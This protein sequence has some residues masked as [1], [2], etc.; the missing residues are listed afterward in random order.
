MFARQG[1]QAMLC[2]NDY[3]GPHISGFS[4][5]K[6]LQKTRAEHTPVALY[7]YRLDRAA[8][9]AERVVCALA[10]ALLDRGFPVHLMSWDGADTHTFYPLKKEVIWH[11]LGFRQGLIDK[12]RRSRALAR[13]LRENGI[14]TLVGFVMSGDKAVY[15]AVKLAGV[16]LVVAERNAPCMYHVRY[17]AIQRRLSFALLHL[18]DRITVQF[19]KFSESY[20][21][22]LR[23]RIEVIPNPV[24]A[25]VRHARPGAPGQ[26]GRFTLL[27]V[28]RLDSVQKRLDC[29]LHAFGRV[30]AEQKDWDLRIIGDGPEGMALRELVCKLGI[31]ERVHFEG[32]TP[33]IFAAYIHAHLFVIPSLWE[34]FPNALA[35]ALSHGLPAVGFENAPGVADLIK[36]GDTGWLAKG[37]DDKAALGRTLRQA[38]A[39]HQERDRRGALAIESMAAYD[40]ETQ[41]DRWTALLDSLTA[42]DAS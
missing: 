27:T 16:R 18:A 35:E 7:F 40:A 14:R 28:S 17:S 2:C 19:Q 29:L 21:V 30:S 11:R 13:V 37:V 6:R 9:G 8:G 20:P 24:P 33:D 4:R 5:S 15:T 1:C 26:N 12:I 23:D 34:G 32:S 36:D 42:E 38:M 41:F 31:S 22:G 3:Y 39:D 25:A 10:N